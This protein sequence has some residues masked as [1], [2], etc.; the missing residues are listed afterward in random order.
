MAITPKPTK[1]RIGALVIGQ[2]P[3]PD[4][5]DPLQQMIPEWDIITA[6]ALDHLHREALPA[7]QSDY[8][9]MTRMRSGET[10]IVEESFLEM[11]LQTAVQTLEAAN[12]TAII[13]LCAGTF[14]TV[15]S[16]RPLIKPFAV[17]HTVF[18]KQNVSSLGFITPVPEQINPI[19]AR[20]KAAGIRPTVW[21]EPLDN[22]DQAHLKTT[23]EIAQLE[24]LV[25]DYVG[26]SPQQVTQLRQQT[27]IP[28]FD[29]GELAM[30][31]I[32]D[33]IK[34]KTEEKI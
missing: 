9:L 21:A 15:T 30:Q 11:Q 17:G 5:T 16:N 22:I 27:T 18:A 26:H 4:L 1:K 2:S 6:G 10:V 19:K 3:R 8:P 25:L 34:N 31:A 24:G 33:L 12:V 32:V 23:I 13:L 20:W 29:L 7:H 28:V 14:D